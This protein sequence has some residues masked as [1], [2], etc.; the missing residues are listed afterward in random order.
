MALITCPECGAQ[1]SDKAAAC[2]HCGYPL[3]EQQSRQTEAPATE[4]ESS[5]ERQFCIDRIHAG[6]VYI[7]CKCGCTI[8]KPFSFVSRNSQESYTLNETLVCPQCHAE[9]VPRTVLTRTPNAAQPQTQSPGKTTAD[10]LLVQCINCGKMTNKYKLN[11]ESCGKPWNRVSAAIG[12][13]DILTVFPGM[14]DLCCNN[15]GR[16]FSRDRK[17]FN[18]T[19]STTAVVKNPLSCPSCGRTLFPG[20]VVRVKTMPSV[21]MDNVPKNLAKAK[22]AKKKIAI[23]VA[24]IAICAVGVYLCTKPINAPNSTTGKK[25]ESAYTHSSGSSSSSSYSSSSSSKYDEDDIKAGVYVLAK[26]CVKNHLKAPSTAEFTEMWNCGFSKGDDNI[27][28]M[29]G[30]VDSENSFGAMLREQ[31]SIMAEVNG[32]KV[33]LVMVT[34]GDQMY[35]D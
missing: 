25:S 9:A 4:P 33:S 28:M 32:D 34:I 35:F 17:F 2:P 27:Y 18:D 3:G 16:H 29:T 7:R 26:K 23:S 22:K 24:A 12:E 31:W 21:P 20:T 13:F 10:S 15:C 30:Y 19:I 6:K 5:V 8:E 11:C 14:V 1:V